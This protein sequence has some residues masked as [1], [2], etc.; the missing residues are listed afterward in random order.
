VIINFDRSIGSIIH[1]QHATIIIDWSKPR[2]NKFIK[3][4]CYL[5]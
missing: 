3:Y 5:A 1:K 2:S 4:Y